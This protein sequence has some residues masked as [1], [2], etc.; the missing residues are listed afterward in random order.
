M[1]TAKFTALALILAG[2]GGGGDD[3]AVSANPSP[4]PVAAAPTPAAPG[5]GK[6]PEPAP[7]PIAPAPK[8]PAAPEPQ[9]APTPP[10][11]APTPVE[12]ISGEVL[13]RAMSTHFQ[14]GS[15]D[16]AI[17]NPIAIGSLEGDPTNQAHVRQS[18]T[19]N[20]PLDPP[21]TVYAQQSGTFQNSNLTN[22]SIGVSFLH[23]ILGTELAAGSGPYTTILTRAAPFKL[24]ESAYVLDRTLAQWDLAPWFA[25]LQ[26][27]SDP[28]SNT[29]FRLCWH[30][31]LPDVIRL[32]CGL[33][34]RFSAEHRGVY[35]VDDSQGLGA[36][37]WATR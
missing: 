11:A 31:R 15:A 25:Q 33:F 35:I 29:V 21:S 24:D 12:T 4:P 22:A 37:T 36:R 18:L 20:H 2:C 13:R 8:P 28:R 30:Y 23:Q 5:P 16:P 34:D 1:R 9:P 32:S 10:P 26:V 6:A 14:I 7:A 19:F 17:A 27:Q 3:T